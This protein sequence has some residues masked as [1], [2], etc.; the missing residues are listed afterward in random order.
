MSTYVAVASTFADGDVDLKK[1][2]RELSKKQKVA[3]KALETLM[4]T[5]EDEKVRLGAAKAIIES[6]ADLGNK[7]NAD[8]LTRLIATAKLSASSGQGR[9]VE[10]TK[11]PLV[12]FTTIR[13]V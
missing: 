3:I 12:D 7:I 2:Y 5:A 13:E 11:R 6:C 10:E 4:L 1:L 8:Q 9:L